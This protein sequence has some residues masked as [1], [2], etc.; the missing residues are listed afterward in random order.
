MNTLLLSSTFGIF[1]LILLFILCFVGVH[2]L[3]L[4]RMGQAYR[5]EQR[6]SPPPSQTPQ[7]PQKPQTPQPKQEPPEKKEESD[8]E[9]I[10]YIVE[11]K[12]RVKSTFTPP[13]Q[14]RFK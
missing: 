2:V 4:A 8:K 5:K 13:K 3:R 10:Y 1:W 12:K 6:Q 11:R 9:P 7:T 14:I